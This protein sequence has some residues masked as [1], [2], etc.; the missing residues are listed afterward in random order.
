MLDSPIG[1]KNDERADLRAGHSGI[2]RY[3]RHTPED[4]VLDV[5]GRALG[6]GARVAGGDHQEQ[7][8]RQ[9]IHVV[10]SIRGSKPGV[11]F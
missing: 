6:D 8:S 4:E 2:T 5:T 11:L 9:G 7:K 1:D 10:V 3:A